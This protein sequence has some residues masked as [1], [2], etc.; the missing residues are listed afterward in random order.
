MSLESGRIKEKKLT[1]PQPIPPLPPKERAPWQMHGLGTQGAFNCISLVKAMSRLG[2]MPINSVFIGVSDRSEVRSAAEAL[3]EVKAGIMDKIASFLGITRS[4]FPP[5]YVGMPSNLGIGVGSVDEAIR[6]HNEVKKWVEREMIPWCKEHWASHLI[7]FQGIGYSG[8]IFG[9][10]NDAILALENWAKRQFRV[11][12]VHIATEPPR[13]LKN[14][15]E[16]F[17]FSDLISK[18]NGCKAFMP[19]FDATVVSYQGMKPTEERPYE[20]MKRWNWMG[21]I[22]REKAEIVHHIAFA[23]HS[24]AGIKPSLKEVLLLAELS[25]I[26]TI[27]VTER[28]L[29]TPMKKGIIGS[30][31]NEELNREGLRGCTRD[32]LQDL[33]ENGVRREC[34]LTCFGQLN[35][36]W[37]DTIKAEAESFGLDA[38]INIA[39]LRFGSEYSFIVGQGPVVNKP[40]RFI[41]EPLGIWKRSGST[42]TSDT[43]EIERLIPEDLIRKEQNEYFRIFDVYAKALKLGSAHEMFSWKN[44]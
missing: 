42:S 43:G 26:K 19:T 36:D 27:Y 4:E 44:Y 38:D 7:R 22:S 37:H 28:I 8:L 5:Y 31:V 32:V 3:K 39:G 14:L 17:Q 12:Y 13:T 16:F 30:R 1:L 18:E 41:E 29:I 2:N 24:R 23:I 25:P 10:I 33:K 9:N 21:R 15:Q 20:A 40:V 34:V 35:E 6:V 11:T